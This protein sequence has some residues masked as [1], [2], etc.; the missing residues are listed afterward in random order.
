MVKGDKHLLDKVFAWFGKTSGLVWYRHWYFG[1]T[2]LALIFGRIAQK[3]AQLHT[4]SGLS[5][6]ISKIDPVPSVVKMMQGKDMK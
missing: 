1:S 2:K 3:P 4:I 5:F 6:E